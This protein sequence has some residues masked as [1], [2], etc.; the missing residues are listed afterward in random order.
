M[1]N[2]QTHF[3]ITTSDLLMRKSAHMPSER[4]VTRIVEMLMWKCMKCG[5]TYLWCAEMFSAFY[6]GLEQR[7][8]L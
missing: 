5:K 6:S 1:K 7:C 4:D 3:P 8:I 2:E